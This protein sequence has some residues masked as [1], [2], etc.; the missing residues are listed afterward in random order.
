MFDTPVCTLVLFP[1]VLAVTRVAFLGPAGPSHVHASRLP[2]RR[3]SVQ[4]LHAVAVR[5]AQAPGQQLP[6][7]DQASWE[8][9][10]SSGKAMGALTAESYSGLCQPSL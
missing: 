3:H 4:R 9:N 2:M 1:H 10:A 7:F 5:E 8:N 6:K